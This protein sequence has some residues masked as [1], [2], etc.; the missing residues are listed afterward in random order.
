MDRMT[1]APET[2]ERHVMHVINL[3]DSTRDRAEVD[4]LR[5]IAAD[6]IK[7]SAGQAAI[8]AYENQM[9]ALRRVMMAADICSKNGRM[10]R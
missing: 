10:E 6:I 3:I 1:P 2:S 4:R 7:E 9:A 5:R 8:A